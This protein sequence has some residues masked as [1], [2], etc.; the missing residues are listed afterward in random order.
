M[1]IYGPVRGLLVP[2]A[3][4]TVEPEMRMLLT[5]TLLSARLRSSSPDSRTRGVEYLERVEE[6]LLD[7]D[8]APLTAVGFAYTACSYFIGT[9]RED[10]LFGRLSSTRGH[11]VLAAAA[12]VRAALT[13][14]G[15]TR[16][17]LVSPYPAWLHE[18]ADRYWRG[19]GFEP[20]HSSSL[21]PDMGD[22]RAIY[23][24]GPVRVGDLAKVASEVDAI[25]LSGTGLPSLPTIAAADT[26]GVPVV[27]SNLCLAWAMAGGAPATL[28]AFLAP[29]AAWRSKLAQAMTEAGGG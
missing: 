27:S 2:Q 9:V 10:E 11:P 25:V 21:V 22:T 4:T 5:G 16:I 18:A 19:A 3:N 23:K 14:L 15:A 20:V 26:L 1:S 7:F 17:G 13:V 8:T 28:R 6:F 12:S 29:D 24:L